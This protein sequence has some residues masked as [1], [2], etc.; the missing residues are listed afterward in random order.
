VPRD[1]SGIETFERQQ[2]RFDRNASRAVQTV[3]S[4]EPSAR[5]SIRRVA[6][7]VRDAPR[8]GRNLATLTP[9]R[10]I[11]ELRAFRSVTVPSATI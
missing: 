8:F 6:I 5:R 7:V 2:A 3:P 4:A 10:E 9:A 11:A 1:A